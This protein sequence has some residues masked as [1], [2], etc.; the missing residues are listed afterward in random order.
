MQARTAISLS[1]LKAKM[2]DQADNLDPASTRRCQTIRTM[3]SLL[4]IRQQRERQS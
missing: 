2:P 1:E 4:N 3:K